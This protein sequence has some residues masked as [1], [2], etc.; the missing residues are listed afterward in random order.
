MH[1]ARVY[2]DCVI[3]RPID[4]VKLFATLEAKLFQEAG[5]LSRWQELI[6]NTRKKNNK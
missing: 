5:G 4:K 6:I 2:K 1:Y 3:S